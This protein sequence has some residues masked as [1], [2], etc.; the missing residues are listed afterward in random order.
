MRALNVLLA[1]AVSLAI[2]FAVFEFGLRLHPSFAPAKT[3]NRFDPK[4]GWSKEPGTEVVRKVAGEKVSFAINR[5]GLRDDEDEG[6]DKAADVYRVLML[7]DSFV[8]GYTVERA[9]LFVDRLEHW[10]NAEGRQVDVVNAGTEGWSTDQE[11]AWFLDEGVRYRPDLVLLFPYENDVYWNGQ[12]TYATGAHKPRFEPDGA[13]ESRALAAPAPTPFLKKTAIAKFLGTLRSGLRGALGLQRGVAQHQFVPEGFDRA[14][15]CEWA[16]LLEDPPAFLED[17]VVR[18]R[19]ALRA[20]KD[21]AG[22]VGARLV[23]VPIPSKNAVD[24]EEREF[25]RTWEP[26]GLRGLPDERWSPNRPVNLFID[27]ASE[28][29]IDYLDPR[30]S[31]TAATRAGEKLYFERDVEWHFNAAGNERFA[32]FLHDELDRREIFPP[33]HRPERSAPMPAVAA[34]A[35]SFPKW[36]LVFAAL[37]TVLGV[38]YVLT[39][40]KEKKLPGILGVGALLALIFAIVLGGSQLVRA[41][42]PAWA[43]WLVLGFVALILGF[44]AYKLGRRIGTILELLRSFTLRGH[45]YLM[46]LVVVLLSVGSLLVVAASSP[47]IAP[48]IYTLF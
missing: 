39:Y 37:W 32:E 11:V 14:L 42:P 1:I 43:P 7:G 17:A 9:E 2:G 41:I 21:A 28:L 35:R 6:P 31:L 23:V 3:M 45:W 10:W 29:Q 25:F 27:L 4:L 47:L 8:L 30:E 40:P 19:G 33:E 5:N 18:T 36:P 22:S 26:R 48:F 12:T 13:L 20:L 44:V 24:P 38:A 15:S 16:V 34:S 46:P